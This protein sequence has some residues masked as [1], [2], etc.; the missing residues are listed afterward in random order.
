[1]FFNYLTSSQV[2]QSLFFKI[3]IAESRYQNND[4]YLSNFSTFLW[5][6]GDYLNALKYAKKA[7]KIWEILFK[8]DNPKHPT[9]IVIYGNIAL[10]YRDMNNSEMSIKYILKRLGRE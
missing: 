1:L 8:K 2:Q 7:L 3:R 6:Y 10:I 9:L 4:L 5:A